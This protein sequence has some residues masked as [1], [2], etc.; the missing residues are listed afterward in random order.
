METVDR[1]PNSGFVYDP[2]T[3]EAKSDFIED[4]VVST[5]NENEFFYGTKEDAIA[6]G[7]IFKNENDD[8]TD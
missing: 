1:T 6:F 3:M 8:I 4:V 7:L 5:P 2:V